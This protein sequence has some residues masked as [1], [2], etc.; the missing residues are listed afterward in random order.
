MADFYELLALIQKNHPDIIALMQKPGVAKVIFDMAAAEQAGKPWSQAQLDAALQATEYYRSSDIQQREWDKLQITDPAT[1]KTKV[2]ATK[3][4]IDD[5]QM[6]LGVS[7]STAGGLS[8]PGF[9][10]LAK[11]VQMG[12]TPDQIKYNLLAIAGKSGGGDVGAM[13]ADIKQ[14]FNDYGVPLSDSAVMGWATKLASGAVDQQ[15]ILG[16]AQQQ[17][18]SLFPGLKDAISRGIS[19]RQYADPYLQIAAQELGINPA[20]VSLTD[21]KWMKAINA[22]DTKTGARVSMNLSDWTALVR[23]DP[24]YGYDQTSQAATQAASFATQLSK[25]MGAVG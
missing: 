5:L 1:A 15:A 9:Q 4:L 22:I 20:N 19:V 16:Y 12:W 3:R 8:S 10:F 11:A 23:S 24:T 2:E 6:Q 14:T 7:I 13:A 17:A 25:M 21:P 18:I